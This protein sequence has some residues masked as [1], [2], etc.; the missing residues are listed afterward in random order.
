MNVIGIP[1]PSAVPGYID[2]FQTIR[3]ELNVT[4]FWVHK[5]WVLYEILHH[6][7]KSLCIN[8]PKCPYKTGAS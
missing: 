8:D 1:D 7:I 6:S 5:I 3:Q 2:I 4:L